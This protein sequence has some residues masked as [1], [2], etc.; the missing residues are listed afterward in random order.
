MGW[1]PDPKT[2]LLNHIMFLFIDMQYSINHVRRRCTDIGYVSDD[3]EM[4][5]DEAL[6]HLSFIPPED[7]QDC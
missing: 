2:P 4:A 1:K 7:D 5:I 3:V 6:K